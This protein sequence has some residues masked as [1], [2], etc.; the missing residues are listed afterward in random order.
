ML[1]KIALWKLR[2]NVTWQQVRNAYA[3]VIRKIE[4]Q[5]TTRYTDWDRY[6]RHIY[7]KV[8]SS[9][10]PA[11]T[12]KAK[13]K[14]GQLMET[15]WFCKQYQKQE[16]CTRELPHLVSINTAH[17]TITRNVQHICATCW[18]DERVK[19]YHPECSSECPHKQL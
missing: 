1:Q 16:G 9:T 10:Y 3:H 12:E 6:E 18:L 19:R 15:T 4:N 8:V 5:E 2:S 7:D 14:T 11:K 17:G 13:K